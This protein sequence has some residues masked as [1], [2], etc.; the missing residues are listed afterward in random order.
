MHEKESFVSLKEAAKYART[1][2]QAIYKAIKLGQLKAEKVLVKG[3]WCWKITA[4]DIDEYRKNKY[5][6]E[7]RVVNGLRLFDIEQNRWS[8]V[9]ASKALSEM[10]KIPY[11]VHHVYY[12]LRIG[13]LRAMKYG[14]AWVIAREALVSLY[15]E[16]KE[17]LVKFGVV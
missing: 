2:R 15:E 14:R 11:P 9:Q 3:K 12:L 17:K 6:R 5:S 16:E 13:K 4:A 10:L 8:V 1:G 7:K